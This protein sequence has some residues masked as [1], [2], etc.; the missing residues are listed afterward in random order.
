MRLEPQGDQA[1][2]LTF[3]FT[4]FPGVVVHAGAL[5][6]FIFPPCWCDACDET[7]ITQIEQLEQLVLGVAAGSYRER[8][9][10]GSKGVCQYA[11]TNPTGSGLSSGDSG[12]E[13][14]DPARLAVAEQRLQGLPN[15][16]QAWPRRAA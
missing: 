14:M 1:A 12:V 10:V 16:W 7:A 9:P 13:T 5:H 15:G 6:D 3:A 8:Y 11:L 2:P 4:S